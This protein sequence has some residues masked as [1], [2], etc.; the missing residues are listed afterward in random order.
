MKC[1]IGLGSNLGDPFENLKK[2]VYELS[3]HCQTHCRVEKIS[4]IYKTPALI[5]EGASS[6]WMN[7]YLNAVVQIEWSES[8]E[9]LLAQLKEIELKLGRQPSERWAPRVID[10]DLL[11][12]GNQQ[13]NTTILCVP[14]PEI[15]KRSFVLDPLKDIAPDFLV[16]GDS[17][18]IVKKARALK[19]RS[20]LIMGIVNLTPDS[21]SDGGELDS[22]I[23]I[24][25][26]LEHMKSVGLQ[27]IDFGA[28]STRPGA[29]DVGIE[30]EWSRL[31]EPLQWTQ[32]FFSDELL[33]PK[34][35]VD[36]RK[37]QV[38]EKAIEWGVDIINDVSGLDDPQMMQ[39]L[40]DS[41]C[42]Y[43]LT[44]SLSVPA[45]PRKT[46]SQNVDPVIELRFWFEQ[47]CEDFYKAGVPLSRIIFD[48]GIGFGKTPHQSILLLQRMSE[49]CD[50]PVR[51]MVGHSRKSFMKR[52]NLSARHSLDAATLIISG[53]LVRKG[54]DILRVHDYESHLVGMHA[55]SEV[56]SY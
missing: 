34:I 52:W 35:S 29:T 55:M 9:K 48:P 30:K 6:E 37:S 40:K 15:F 42:D 7:P 13:I 44:H 53:E 54:V 50:L 39:V 4:P 25:N 28:E 38:A 47:K 14:H 10:L 23:K 21:F 18:C 16:P 36:T 8:A 19:T 31:K 33:K 46:I 56:I 26:R 12:Y 49:F 51:I 3:A 2:A 1:F 11:T 20:P 27:C 5:P 45:D 32:Q 24:E 17:D 41:D 43:V 22:Q